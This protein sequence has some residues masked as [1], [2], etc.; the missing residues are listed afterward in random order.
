MPR[1]A[2][3]RKRLYGD[4]LIVTR[5]ELAMK[6]AEAKEVLKGRDDREVPTLIS[7]AAGWPA[8]LGLASLSGAEEPGAALPETL[9][10][11]FAEELFQ[12][13]SPPLQS[14]LPQ[15]ALLPT[16][17]PDLVAAGFGKDNAT[18]MLRE[19]KELGFLSGQGS[20][21]SFQPLLRAFVRRKNSVT[22]QHK[23]TE[24]R[25]VAFLLESEEWDEAFDVIRD[26]GQSE[27]LL[28]LFEL[29]HEALL[30][31]GRTATLREWLVFAGST[32][33]HAPLLD[34][35]RAEARAELGQFTGANS[36]ES[37]INTLRA[38]RIAGYTPVT[39]ASKDAAIDAIMLER[40]K[41]LAF[42]GH[43]FWD[44]RRRNLP[45]TRIGTDAP[46]A[47]GATLS[48]GHFRFILPI[49]NAEMQ[50]NKLMVQ[51]AGY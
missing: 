15:L 1:W 43:R 27:A 9:Y 35:I 13:A 31:S 44:L 28:R 24:D 25:L 12:K 47:T 17:T 41:E 33:V 3:A 16:V 23:E 49:P 40:F 10:A 4:Y 19:A 36:A 30:K 7:T 51:N 50:A 38:A 39:F 8:V 6:D 48:A 20:A 42:E 32:D 11:Y 34:L 29:A 22:A 37:D 26:A 18:E 14:A 21:L 45:V 5:D 46:S 2:T